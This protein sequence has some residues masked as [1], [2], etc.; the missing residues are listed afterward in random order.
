MYVLKNIFHNIFLWAHT[1]N[2]ERYM[3]PFCP[4][5]SISSFIYHVPNMSQSLYNTQETEMN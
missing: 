2:E 1:F 5:L 3:H 4:R